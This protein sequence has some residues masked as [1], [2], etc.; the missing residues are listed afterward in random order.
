VVIFN[1]CPL[2]QVSLTRLHYLFFSPLH[3]AVIC[4]FFKPTPSR[5]ETFFKWHAIADFFVETFNFHPFL[6]G[7][8]LEPAC[9]CGQL[10]GW[11]LAAITNEALVSWSFSIKKLV[12]AKKNILP[13]FFFRTALRLAWSLILNIMLSQLHQF[14]QTLLWCMQ[15]TMQRIQGFP[16]LMAQ[17]MLHFPTRIVL[18][19]QIDLQL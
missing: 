13:L 5:I 6:L 2:I 12:H 14:L 16:M 17:A 3:D 18:F 9:Y 15:L 4:F 1:C 10:R 8:L 19:L 7:G 11:L